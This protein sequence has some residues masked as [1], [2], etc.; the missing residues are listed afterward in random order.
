MCLAPLPTAAALPGTGTDRL[1][2][3]GGCNASSTGRRP[4]QSLLPWFDLQSGSVCGCSERET[5]DSCRMGVRGGALVPFGACCV[6]AFPWRL[7]LS[8]CFE[9]GGTGA[10][11]TRGMCGRRPSSAHAMPGCSSS[12]ASVFAIIIARMPTALGGACLVWLLCV[13]QRGGEEV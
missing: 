1:P 5:P 12:S 7:P 2:S 13:C 11:R 4:G 6:P 10:Q 8:T 9:E 3:G